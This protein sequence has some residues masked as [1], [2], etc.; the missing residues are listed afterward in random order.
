MSR[1]HSDSGFRIEIHRP[2]TKDARQPHK[3]GDLALSPPD[4]TGFQDIQL[5]DHEGRSQSLSY[6]LAQVFL[7]AVGQRICGKTFWKNM[8][9]VAVPRP[10]RIHVNGQ[11]VPMDQHLWKQAVDALAEEKDEQPS[12]LIP[13]KHT[14]GALLG[15]MQI[16]ELTKTRQRISPGESRDSSGIIFVM[17]GSDAV[18]NLYPEVSLRS[19]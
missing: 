8:T 16:V 14:D 15:N 11:L 17:P 4:A 13:I 7:P 10:L 1:S 18:Y 6:G 19:H 3:I 9:G 2:S 12:G 5:I